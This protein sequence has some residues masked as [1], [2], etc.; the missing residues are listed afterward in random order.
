MKKLLG[1]LL[2]L[3]AVPALAGPISGYPAAT[4]PYGS[5]DTVIGTQAGN[6]VTFS[7][8]QIA[9]LNSIN[10]GVYGTNQAACTAA[11]AAAIAQNK[12][13]HFPGGTYLCSLTLP[14]N[15]PLLIFGDGKQATIIKQPNGAN[16]DVIT[17]A[18]IGTLKGSNTAGGGI[19]NV[20]LRDLTIDGNKA[21]NS[22]GICLDIY[23]HEYVLEHVQIQNCP[24]TSS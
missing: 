16:A 4:T 21:N 11:I 18:N 5:T 14:D 9:A 1:L 12:A 3:W 22:A 6:T 7:P 17:T 15:T 19:F 2:M 24:G 8:T 10:V 20:T 23:G 13:L